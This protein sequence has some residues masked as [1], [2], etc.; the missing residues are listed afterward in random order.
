MILRSRVHRANQSQEESH[1]CQSM[2][3]P[4]ARSRLAAGDRDTAQPA[5]DCRAAD[6]AGIWTVSRRYSGCVRSRSP[7]GYGDADSLGRGVRR[8]RIA[9]KR[10]PAEALGAGAFGRPVV[11]C[12][13]EPCD[14]ANDLGR[15]VLGLLDA[16][17]SQTAELFEVAKG[18]SARRAGAASFGYRCG[19][20]RHSSRVGKR[21]SQEHLH[22][23]V[24]AAE[25]VV[26]PADERVVDGWVEAKQDLPALAHV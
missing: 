8:V 7:I 14:V 18:S 4:A 16:F 9:R 5:W 23:G 17:V 10:S 13:G 3:P 6:E 20:G 2:Q 25:L 19:M 11:G 21:P 26:G 15:P 1:D 22:L 24:D 12:S